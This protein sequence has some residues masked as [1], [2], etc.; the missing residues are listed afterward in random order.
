MRKNKT[1]L[2]DTKNFHLMMERME[3]KLTIDE[4]NQKQKKLIL[5]GFP[6]GTIGELLS[7]I[8][9]NTSEIEKKLSSIK[10]ALGST[11]GQNFLRGLNFFSDPKTNMFEIGKFDLKL[12]I[13]TLKKINP[14]ISSDVIAKLKSV[15]KVSMAIQKAQK[16]GNPIV[17]MM[18]EAVESGLPLESV[19]DSIADTLEVYDDIFERTNIEGGG[20]LREGESISQFVRRG[21]VKDGR[22]VD[23]VPEG[24]K[25]RIERES[26]K[27]ISE[28]IK[29]KPDIEVSTT[30]DGPKQGE[31]ILVGPN[32]ESF[33]GKVNEYFRFKGWKK[34]A[35]NVTG[36]PQWWNA[37][38]KGK[39]IELSG[40]NFSAQVGGA[41]VNILKIKWKVVK[42]LVIP[43][44]PALYAWLGNCIYKNYISE[45]PDINIMKDGEVVKY[46]PT[47]SQCFGDW[48]VDENGKTVN[49][50]G[51]NFFETM[52]GVTIAKHTAIPWLGSWAG[53]KLETYLNIAQNKIIDELNKIFEGKTLPELLRL[54]CDETTINILSESYKAE[55]DK[56]DLGFLDSVL[57]KLPGIDGFDEMKTKFGADTSDKILQVMGTFSKVKEWQEKTYAELEKYLPEKEKKQSYNVK[58]I[59][60]AKCQNIRLNA[61]VVAVKNM[62]GQISSFPTKSTPGKNKNGSLCSN[63]KFWEELSTPLGGSSWDK[64]TCLNNKSE[65]ENIKIIINEAVGYEGY[66]DLTNNTLLDPDVWEQSCKNL[67]MVHE[68]TPSIAEWICEQDPNKSISESD[69]GLEV[70][71][72]KVSVMV[73]IHDY[74]WQKANTE[75]LIIS[76]E[77]VVDIRNKQARSMGKPL[78]DPN[79]DGS[80]ATVDEYDVWTYNLCNT[81]V[82][83]IYIDD[84]WCLPKNITDVGKERKKNVTTCKEEFL[85]LLK[86]KNV[87]P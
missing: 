25:I 4:V 28:D 18:E 40:K 1:L 30:K 43:F 60:K 50:I 56:T 14:D 74:E 58:D 69:A 75:D 84:Y 29:G 55:L 19:E 39:F 63:L 81:N 27:K 5:E 15:E 2:L 77:G 35:W 24:T 36:I 57:E 68:G 72:I 76:S 17:K 11:E 31:E 21:I 51:F 82:Q 73:S 32:G 87:C 41:F 79:I 46:Q 3:N 65:I 86:D 13:N 53:E 42:G 6:K 12:W 20:K 78:F 7:K 9:R 22:F 70:E 37:V 54:K 85:K 34:F 61:I 44:P 16:G 26:L 48:E 62:N 66:R 45:I 23:G 10:V 71:L 67:E 59:I 47:L 64:E 33:I 38:S 52:P 49:E 83:K 80:G 8:G